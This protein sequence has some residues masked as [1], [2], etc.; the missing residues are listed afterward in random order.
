MKERTHIQLGFDHDKYIE[1]QS[2]YI[3]ER[4]G[5]YDKLYLEFGGKLIGDRHAARCLPGYRENAKL[6]LLKSLRD[7]AEIVISVGAMDIEANKIRSD[8]L[9]TYDMEVL[10]LIDDLR[11]FDLLVNSVV[12]TRYSDQPAAN[13]FRRKLERRGIKTYVHRPIAGYPF[14]V[15]YIVS[16][17]GYGS[18]EYIETTRPIVVVTA[19]GPG[20]GKLAT[21]LAQIYNEFRHGKASCYAKFETFPVWNL[22]L[23]HPLNVAYEAATADLS[24]CNMVDSYHLDA[25]GVTTTNYNRDMEMFPVMKRL[26]DRIM[27]ES[28]YKSP[29]DMGVNRIADGII[30]DELVREASRQEIIRRYL[31]ARCDYKKGVITADILSRNQF[32][33]ENEGLK[34]EMRAPVVPAREYNEQVCQKTGSSDGMCAVAIELPSGKII[35]GRQSEQMSAPAAALLNAVKHLGGIPDSMHLL[36]DSVLCPILDLKVNK[37]KSHSKV[38]SAEEAL[39]ALSLSAVMSP[40]AKTAIEMLPM[41]ATSQ[42]HCTSMANPADDRLYS[43]L[44]IDLTCDDNFL[45]QDLLDNRY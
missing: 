10:R 19:P 16:D 35:T 34:A 5:K 7:Q 18:L 43:R 12:I 38:M 41:L 21:C 39:M 9:S 44:N 3:M 4:A 1:S 25:Y 26:L 32:I 28:I 33:L 15:D 31:R 24:D 42:A 14:N 22:P 37:L 2:Q 36:P 17:E 13:H 8:F 45:T 11:S 23:K 6:E 27:G 30:N 20:S 40:A 29:T